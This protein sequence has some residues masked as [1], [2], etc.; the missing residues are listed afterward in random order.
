MNAA[1]RTIYLLRHAEPLSGPG[2]RRY[3][4]WSDPPLSATGV[5]QA[6]RWQP[7]TTALNLTAAFCSDLQRSRQ[8][9][10]TILATITIPITADPGLREI[11]LG[12]WEGM[13][14]A[15]V[16]GK[17]PESYEQRGREPADFRPP[18]GESFGDLQQRVMPVFQSIIANTRGNILIVGHAGVN[19][20]ILS[21][22]LGMPLEN[23]FRMGQD[24]AAVNIIA[25]DRNGL[26]VQTLNC[27]P[28]LNTT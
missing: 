2:G 22:L 18:G 5:R 20:V 21:R 27:L 25:A 28:D 16:R 10:E 12:E 17:Y 9:A 11:H 13:T 24:Y 1:E 14:F 19:R 3:I 6:E 26:K 23:I 4:G 15:A 7:I 8:T